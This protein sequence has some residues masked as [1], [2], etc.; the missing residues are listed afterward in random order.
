[1][2]KSFML[3]LMAVSVLSAGE[4][5]FRDYLSDQKTQFISFDEKT[6]VY[7]GY[8]PAPHKVV[9]YCA[10]MGGNLT[11]SL[12]SD[13]G[14]QEIKAVQDDL[15]DPILKMSQEERIARFAKGEESM[16]LKY[17][18]EFKKT[19][20]G[21]LVYNT[22]GMGGEFECKDPSGKALFSA[23]KSVGV[24]PYGNSTV[25]PEFW[26]VEHQAE[27]LRDKV[28]F[29]V[30]NGHKD[31]NWAGGVSYDGSSIDVQ[32]KINEKYPRYESYFDDW[33]TGFLNSSDKQKLG[34]NYRFLNTFGFEVSFHLYDSMN[35]LAEVQYFCEAKKGTFLKEG[36]PFR[37]FLKQF[38]LDGA[39][40]T[41]VAT[42]YNAKP[43]SPFEGT[44][45]C[46]NTPEAF[47][48][49]LKDYAAG[50]TPYAIGL[51]YALVKKAVDD[52][53]NQ[54]QQTQ[55][56]SQPIQY[57]SQQQGQVEK[58]K[59]MLSGFFGGFMGNDKSSMNERKNALLSHAGVNMEDMNL[60]A[61]AVA[62]K[63]PFG[64]QQGANVSLA[65]YNG[66]DSSGCDLV[67]IEK[68]V[69]NMPQSK[70]ISNYKVCGGQVISLG[71]T[72][73]LGVPRAKEIDPVIA[74]VKT[75]C[76]AYGAFGSQYQDTVISCR[77]L[78][79]NRCNL[80][81]SI[82]Q[83]NMLVNKHVENTCK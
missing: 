70:R 4:Y 31:S 47:T 10:I 34:T 53:N 24:R 42:G 48:M 20:M 40:S 82:V 83:N 16:N 43:S 64:S 18:D 41:N 8:V 77:A 9:S 73:L 44:Y 30:R 67:S 65:Q 80:E 29:T 71:E 45:A 38:Y 59:E 76:K 54:V 75:Q 12:V 1:M 37:L 2:R 15:L 81:I 23:H 3:S 27:P 6:T 68:S 69:T 50:S 26:V 49:E 35:Q 58:A 46:V 51:N 28:H 39:K 78:D 36:K 19:V 11:K 14:A 66:K 33:K 7:E 13:L 32:N 60:V 79:Q 55:M 72:G 17:T 22:Y 52:K 63:A 57:S 21:S 56:I 5:G 61:N 25:P 74:Q 62:T